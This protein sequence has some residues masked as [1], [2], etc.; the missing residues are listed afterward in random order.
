MENRVKLIGFSALLIIALAVIAFSPQALA[1]KGQVLFTDVNGQP[2]KGWRTGEMLFITIIDPDENR[3]SDE[4]ELIQGT[5]TDELCAATGT[6]EHCKVPLVEVVDPNTGDV[7]TT[8]GGFVMQEIGVNSGTFRNF[9]GL[10][11]APL[12][13]NA[14]ATPNNGILEV[15]DNDTIYVF[16]TDP[17]DPSD[18]DADLAKI[19][20]TY[21][22]IKITDR[23]GTEVNLWNVGNDVFVTVWDDDENR[24]PTAVETIEGV[25]LMN[26]RTGASEILTLVE[27]GPNT[28]IF[29]NVD[30]VLLQ[31][32]FG[33]TPQ[34]SKDLVLEVLDKDTI[35]AFYRAPMGEV[36]PP[37][38]VTEDCA[39]D[40]TGKLQFCRALSAKTVAPGASFTI[41][42]KLTNK[43]G[44]ALQLPAFSD[45]LPTGFTPE[46]KTDFAT[47]LD[48]GKTA[49]FTY[50][51]TAS[52]TPGTYTIT[53][54]AKAVGINAFPVSSTITV[55][56]T[57]AARGLSTVSVVAQGTATTSDGI[58]FTRTVPDSVAPGATFYVT[59]KITN[60]TAT[61]LDLVAYKDTLPKGFTPASVSNFQQNLAPGA[62]KE[63]T[64]KAT[65]SSVAGDFVITGKARSTGMNPV[66]LDSPIKV[67]TGPVVG[68]GIADPNDPSD[69]ALDVAKVAE[70]NPSTVTFT[71][72]NGVEKQEFYIVEDIY[73]TVRDDDE[74]VDSD[75]AETVFV[76]IYNSNGGRE[77][78]VPLVETGL[79]TGVFRNRDGIRLIGAETEFGRQDMQ[80]DLR[81]FIAA[82][83]RDTIYVEYADKEQRT[84]DPFDSDYAV[85]RVKSCDV[86]TARAGAPS[87]EGPKGEATGVYKVWFTSE[88]W[89]PIDKVKKGQ[90]L[91][92]KIEE[93]DQDEQSELADS[94]VVTL[95]DRNTGDKETMVMVETGPNTH[96]F[97]GQGITMWRPEQG[98]TPAMVGDGVLQIED[99][100]TIFV[101]YHDPNNPTDFG[102]AKAELA[103]RPIWPGPTASRT[104][105]TDSQGRDMA[106]FVVGDTIYVT[107][108]DGDENRTAG[109]VDTIKGALTVEN[110]RTGA[111]VVVDL[112]ETGPDTGVFL[113]QPITSGEPGT[114]MMMIVEPGD[115]LKASY[116]DPDDP[117]DTSD[118][119][120]FI[121][122]AELRVIGYLN[123]PNPLT[124]RTM[125]KIV[126]VGVQKIHVWVYD[127]AGRMVFDSGEVAGSTLSWNGGECA[128]GVYLYIIQAIGK[129]RSE[130]SN[131]MKLVIRR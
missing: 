90:E 78:H 10:Y 114:G 19:G 3:D 126:G 26:P 124:V 127:L 86:F 71:N 116:K 92:V 45:K 115:T 125:F 48:A 128:N 28:G 36:V 73:V 8:D 9:P 44:A 15:K 119:D 75:L 32:K 106:K 55:G 53:G 62:T 108:E 42:V 89:N 96:V 20:F 100:D 16:Y 74:N 123:M 117:T 22:T 105:F 91:F 49:T 76:N 7:E 109:V 11:I 54:T 94:F 112:V 104:R 43:S 110:P 66:Q 4:V 64:Y 107:V 84:Y 12:K 69:F 1:S 77:L 111:K 130:T 122:S 88:A 129:N 103:P 120:V 61:T 29:R 97:H 87:C 59:V 98:M 47:S 56:A 30:G 82:H 21:A 17:S 63:W 68:P 13:D 2:I 70:P 33:T 24:D 50:T 72:E 58:E 35:V 118:D 25:T 113:S 65:A 121:E 83:N 93:C 99:R 23:A 79:N 18:I 39:T 85:A 14:V 52:S 101:M 27:T 67:I 5:F 37:P 81:G 46:S 102:L 38:P 95:Y 131:V 41:T 51:A 31:D 60:K 80:D 40:A 6:D 34:S 57:A